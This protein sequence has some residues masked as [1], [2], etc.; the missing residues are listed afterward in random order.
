MTAR[1]LVVG[2]VNV[3]LL[4]AADR[5]PGPGETVVGPGVERHGGGTGANAVVAAVHYCG[6]VGA[7]DIGSEALT[8]LRAEGVDVADVA[9]LGGIPTGTGSV[10]GEDGGRDRRTK[11]PVI[12]ML[13]QRRR[14]MDEPGDPAIFGRAC[15]L[16]TP[17]V[18]RRRRPAHLSPKSETPLARATQS[19]GSSRPRSRPEPPLCRSAPVA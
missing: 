18:P 3:D 19:T 10:G 16:S 13:G 12:V 7:D 6:A 8:E 15:W 9:V 11:A 17:T 1:V 14:C 2:A 4:V 5:L